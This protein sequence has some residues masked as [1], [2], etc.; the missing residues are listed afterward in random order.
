MAHEAFMEVKKLAELAAPKEAQAT[1][2]RA[3][4]SAGDLARAEQLET[5]A[6]HLRRQ[7]DAHRATLA[8]PKSLATP[9][10]GY[11][12]A[13]ALPSAA[14]E[15]S[16]KLTSNKARRAL[17]QKRVRMDAA[18]FTRM[19]D[20]YRTPDGGWDIAK[21]DKALERHWLPAK[22]FD[23]ETVRIAKKYNTDARE[24]INRINNI[25]KETGV[26][27]RRNATIGN[28]TSE[29][30]LLHETQ[31]GKKVGTIGDERWHSVKVTEAINGLQKRIAFLEKN[32]HL[33]GKRLINSV[34]KAIADAKARIADM[35]PALEGWNRRTKDYPVI[36]KPDGTLRTPTK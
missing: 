30:A 16:S 22:T 21:A 20:A 24:N 28:G 9:G 3:R 2:L 29:A 32:K 12:A 10:R 19:L 6:A 8:D 1:R 4:N 26:G 36:W 27:G 7:Q 18:D 14:S 35:Q 31:T 13:N 11:V 25:C 5:E 33:F 23:A 15:L 17:E 34:D